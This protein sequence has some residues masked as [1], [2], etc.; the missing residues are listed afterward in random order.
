MNKA[1]IKVV[2]KRDKFGKKITLEKLAS[3]MVSGFTEAK[4]DNEDLA[5]MVQQG[6]EEAKIENNL[7]FTKLENKVDGLENKVD[8]LE[9][10]QEQIKLRQDNVAYRFELVEV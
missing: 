1:K 3:M 8:K 2:N 5:A 7:R 4:K 10:N 6:F 9:Q